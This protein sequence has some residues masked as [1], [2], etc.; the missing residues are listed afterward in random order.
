MALLL[1]GSSRTAA[2]SQIQLLTFE[3]SEA[4]VVG[5]EAVVLYANGHYSEAR[6]AFHSVAMRAQK[7]GI[8]RAAAMNWNNAGVCS[9]V[10]SRFRA[11]LEDFLKAR[12]IAEPAHEWYALAVA[13]NS[14]ANLYIHMGQ[15]ELAMRVANEALAATVGRV[16]PAMRA[17]LLTQLGG[18]LA[19][20]HRLPE[21]EPVY[22]QAIAELMDQ[23]ILD[24]Q[25]LYIAALTWGQF[26]YEYLKENRLD[27]AEWAL[28]EAL[29]LMRMHE[30]KVSASLLSGLAKLKGR[31]GDK[32]AAE[33]LFS[34]AL[35]LPPN[36]TPRYQTYVDRGQFR[37]QAGDLRGALADF[38]KARSIFSEMRAD[39]VPADQD[40]VAL[41]S[42]LSDIFEGLVDAGSRLARQSGDK[43]IL[44]ETFDAAEENRLWSLRA[45][46]PS[47][48]DWRTKLPERYWDA[49]ARYQALGRSASGNTAQV[50]KKTG[51][52][53]LELQQ[54][55]AEAAG[56]MV[57]EKAQSPL[58]HI[59]A[60]LDNDTVL[61]SFHVSNTSSWVWA[62]DRHHANVYPLPSMKQIQPELAA[63]GK[64]LRT[65]QPATAL[66]STLYR[67]LF[68]A[69]PTGYL[70]HRRWLLELSGP[71]YDLPFAALV[72]GHDGNGP[73]YLV[74]RAELQS[75]PNALLAERGSIP[76]DGAF[77]GVSDPVYN[78]A[79]AR[80]TGT[81]VKPDFLLARLPNTSTEVQACARAWNSPQTH[82][83]AGTMAQLGTVRSAL[84]SNPAII[85]FATHVVTA[86]GDFRSGLIALGLN[87]AGEMGLLGP[88]EIVA[89]P[90]T[91]K[92]VVMDGC[93]SAQGEALPNAGLMGL[94]RAW[95]GAGAKS[96]LAT[97]W[98]IPDD[99]AQSLMTDFYR[100]LRISADHS[101]AS[102]LRQAQLTALRSAREREYPADW[103]GYF[104]LSRML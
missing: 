49:L 25:D 75:L 36:L 1:T 94:T 39:I 10:Q 57:S 63:F 23:K 44:Q 29:R 82:L 18:A 96:V 61:L 9:L 69:V 17:T 102:A 42:G 38:R 4:K 30:F 45:L 52:L 74:E 62:V 16:S 34:A 19:E 51:D 31:Q 28:S 70:Q 85:H 20:L 43:A 47:P 66:G 93:H 89:R 72:T 95:I 11:A 65:G 88:K 68:F 8:A 21:A 60:V 80:Y 26:G 55:E 46:I 2:D 59:S 22:R 14:L 6:K 35:A 92:L 24:K 91:A 79:D 41:E 87:P 101:P 33:S 71:L 27:K 97:Q 77:L 53:R 98:D 56:N 73:Q 78:P 54:I 83:L 67:D 76:A 7:E 37:L 13:E 32:R 58:A 104:L 103:A 86:P 5:S 48:N 84:G 3:Q 12:Q 64:A 90:V 99:S 81:R 50:E 100:A 40:R 15:P